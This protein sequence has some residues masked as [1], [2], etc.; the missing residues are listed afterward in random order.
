MDTALLHCMDLSQAQRDGV[1]KSFRGRQIQM[2]VATALQLV[3]LM[4]ILLHVVNYQFLT[5]ETY[6]HRSGR[7]GDVEN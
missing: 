6:N 7:T 4:L 3:E 1:M 5:K 2:L